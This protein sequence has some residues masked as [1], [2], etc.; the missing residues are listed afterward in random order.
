MIVVYPVNTE[1]DCSEEEQLEDTVAVILFGRGQ[2][3]AVAA[4]ASVP[5]QPPAIAAEEKVPARPGEANEGEAFIIFQKRRLEENFFRML[6][7]RYKRRFVL[8]LVN[9]AALALLLPQHACELN[10]VPPS[11]SSSVAA[12]P[13]KD[14]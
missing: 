9:A 6:L 14:S 7:L 12:L 4:A 5:S 11:S 1:T 10:P 13:L 2:E 3:Q 8:L